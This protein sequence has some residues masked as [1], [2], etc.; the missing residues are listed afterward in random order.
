MDI[1]AADRY[2]LALARRLGIDTDRFQL[3]SMNINLDP[4]N[5]AMV[6]MAVMLPKDEVDAILTLDA[7]VPMEA[8]TPDEQE[9]QQYRWDS[10]PSGGQHPSPGHGYVQGNRHG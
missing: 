5:V 1:T 9:T 3:R 8:S 6:T 7:P 10:G 2:A 4:G